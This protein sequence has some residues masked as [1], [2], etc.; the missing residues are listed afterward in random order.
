MSFTN[1]LIVRYMVRHD[2]SMVLDYCRE[3]GR[4]KEVEE[5]LLSDTTKTET[6]KGKLAL[7]LIQYACDIIKGRWEEA[8]EKISN[9]TNAYI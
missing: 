9:Y 6:E 2:F 7:H 3:V 1:D 5:A 4:I 8:E